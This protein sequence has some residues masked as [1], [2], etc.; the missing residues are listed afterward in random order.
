MVTNDG[1]MINASNTIRVFEEALSWL[2][3]ELRQYPAGVLG[4][5]ALYGG[6]SASLSGFPRPI[7][8]VGGDSSMNCHISTLYPINTHTYS[9]INGTFYLRIVA[10]LFR[11]Q[12]SPFLVSPFLLV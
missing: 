3:D 10:F 6:V 1:I 4:S 5:I 12:T 8:E 7:N 11:V 2:N 9:E